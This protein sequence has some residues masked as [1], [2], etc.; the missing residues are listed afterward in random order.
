MSGLLSRNCGRGARRL[1]DFFLAMTFS[2]TLA[3]K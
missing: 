2:F 1:E 3:R